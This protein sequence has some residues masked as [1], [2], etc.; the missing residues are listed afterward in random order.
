MN[1]KNVL[2]FAMAIAMVAMVAFSGF[3]V[4]AASLT[5]AQFPELVHYGII[6]DEDAQILKSFFD[7]EYYK[8]Q[9]PDVVEQY[10]DSYEA[11]FNHFCT[12]GVFEGRTGSADFDPAAYASAYGDLKAQFGADI[13]SY[14]RHYATEGKAVGR[15]I[16]TI[17]ACAEAGIT[18]IGLANDSIVIT[19][20]VYR[21]AVYLGTNDYGA[22]RQSIAIAE[23]RAAATGGSVVI[24]ADDAAGGGSALE[25]LEKVGTL[26]TSDS[27]GIHI[28]IYEGQTAGT[29]GAWEKDY[30]NSVYTLITST[31]GYVAVMSDSVEG[32]PDPA[33]EKATIPVLVK[34]T[35][36][37]SSYQTLNNS[38]AA[39]YI[40]TS[41][42]V[43][44]E[45]VQPNTRETNGVETT[46]TSSFGNTPVVADENGTT[47]T[48]Y[49]VGVGFAESSAESVTVNVAIEGD[50]GL[51]ISDTYTF[52]TE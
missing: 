6:T 26:T 8:E 24:V 51:T 44:T 47:S 3:E 25:G 21:V 17:A 13:L 52:E 28:G 32:M 27:S 29:Y 41:A 2:G 38:T 14:Y 45:E 43:G 40:M 23:Q 5:Q 19:P 39:V 42:E 9:N 49:T 18:V 22:V 20:D 34:A 35:E 33:K 46:V 7:Y 11:L 37:A 36:D 31:N 30:L 16:T 4:S 48:E 12:K 15:D 1:R 10:G 50:D